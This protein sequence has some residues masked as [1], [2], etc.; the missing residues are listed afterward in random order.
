[1]PQ[2]PT[3]DF[4]DSA[5]LGRLS[6]LTLGARMPMIGNVAGIHRSAT[7]GSSIEFAEY[8]KYVQ[9]DDIRHV[10][11]RV[12]ARTD[13]FYIKEF[14]ADTNLRCCLV[15]DISGSMAFVG[16]HGSRLDYAKRLLATLAHLLV[17]QG[18]AAGLVCFSDGTVHDI[19]P[20]DAP[21]HLRTLFDTMADVQATGAT[22][23][24]RTIHDL[25]EK[26]RQRAL[27]IVFSDL[28][29]P[30]APLMD[31]FEHMRFRKHDLAV[32]HILDRQELDFSFDRPIRFMDMEGS[33]HMTT[34]PAVIKAGYRRELDR[35]LASMAHGCREFNVDYHRVFTDTD[36]EAAL[37]TFL[38]QRM[39][40]KQGPK[41]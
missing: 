21:S 6:R 34:D 13:R 28:F 33:F 35:Y 16:D 32:F 36:Y 29:T 37:A 22:G 27:V 41:S 38:L 24:V 20:R 9:G 3:R 31:C 4:L 39:T 15:L 26:I 5:V 10:D 11:W 8:R 18:D 17:N 30:V 25:A 12:F 23:I 7:R 1:L 40:K 14:E 2:A 19:P